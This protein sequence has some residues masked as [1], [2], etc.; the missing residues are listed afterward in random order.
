M[1]YLIILA[2]LF[3][4]TAQAYNYD[5]VIHCLVLADKAGVRDEVKL[6]T[7]IYEESGLSND[8]K[9]V[10]FQQGYMMGSI[11]MHTLVHNTT[12]KESA[13]YL[14]ELMCT[15]EEIIGE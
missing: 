12:R 3:A 6:L 11:D 15:A 5:R 4:S 10:R 2:A 14:M 7:T 1:K 13:T 8:M 9:R